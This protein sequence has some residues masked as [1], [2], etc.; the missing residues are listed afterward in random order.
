[1]SRSKAKESVII[2]SFRK[3]MEGI[4]STSVCKSTLDE[5]PFAY[6]NSEMIEN[7]IEPTAIILDKIKPILNIKDKSEGES[8]KDRK[9]KKIKNE[10]LGKERE[11]VSFI[12]MKKFY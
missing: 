7:A 6:K 3:S 10:R 11:E 12:K 4:Y 8:W 5:S 1:M 2:D 9:N